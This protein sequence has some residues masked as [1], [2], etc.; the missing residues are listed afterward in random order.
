MNARTKWKT[1]ELPLRREHFSLQLLETDRP[2]PAMSTTMKKTKFFDDDLIVGRE[3]MC[4]Y[5]PSF[6]SPIL[7]APYC[8]PT[9]PI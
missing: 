4:D 1:K 2:Q 9:N 5:G 3:R 8:Q 6:L 7:S